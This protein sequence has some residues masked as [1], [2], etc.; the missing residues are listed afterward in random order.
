MEKARKTRKGPNLDKYIRENKKRRYMTYRNACVFYSMP[1]YNL[2]R[3]A[4]EAGA[5]WKIR[6]TVLVDLDK[7]D[8]YIEQFRDGGN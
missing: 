2:V 6:K 4:K 1:Y 5:C 7:V 8:V 3:L